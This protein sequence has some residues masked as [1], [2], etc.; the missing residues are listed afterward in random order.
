M[1]DSDAMVINV[2]CVTGHDA[3]DDHWVQVTFAHLPSE[4]TA[5]LLGIALHDVLQEHINPILAGYQ[6]QRRRQ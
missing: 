3:P 4:E 5:E 2:Q 1:S 6:Q